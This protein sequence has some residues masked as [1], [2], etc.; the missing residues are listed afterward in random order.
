MKSAVGNG[1]IKLEKDTRML[2]GRAR[3]YGIEINR[4]TQR[5]CFG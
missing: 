3:T 2:D 5:V 1:V 4:P